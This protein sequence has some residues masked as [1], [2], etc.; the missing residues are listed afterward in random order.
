[1][2]GSLS[3]IRRDLER[4]FPSWRIWYVRALHTEALWYAQQGQTVIDEEHPLDLAEVIEDIELS[5]DTRREGP[6]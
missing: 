5:R 2:S 3:E 6:A 1:M 4:R